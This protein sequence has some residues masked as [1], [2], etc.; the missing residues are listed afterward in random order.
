MFQVNKLKASE[1]YLIEEI[2]HEKKEETTLQGIDEIEQYFEN[3][4]DELRQL[5]SSKTILEQNY[6]ELLEM[7]HVLQSADVLFEDVKIFS[8]FFFSYQFLK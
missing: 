6:C 7:Q 2:L 8:F 3:V 4:D 1:P 5:N